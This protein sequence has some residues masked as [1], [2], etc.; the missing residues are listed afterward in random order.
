MFNL[1]R[2]F[3]T[4]SLLLILV[5]AG[6][7]GWLYREL[8][9]RQ[10]GELAESRNLEMA[11]VFDNAL[12]EDIENW[13]S[14]S[15]GR[16]P[17]AMQVAP[18]VIELHQK[19]VALLHGTGVLQVRLCNRLGDTVFST[20]IARIGEKRLQAAGFRSAINGLAYSELLHYRRVEALVGP[21]SDL[22]V[23]VSHIPLRAAD[24]SVIGSLE[25]HQD[26]SP[27]MAQLRRHLWLVMGGVFGVSITLY[28]LQFLVVRRAQHILAEQESRLKAAR[29]TLEIQVDARTDKLRQ[30]N[31]RLE[32]EIGIR[33][34]AEDKLNYLAYHDPLTGLANRQCFIERLEQAMAGTQ[35]SARR[36]AVLLV[37]LDQFK[38]VN[39]SLG[40]AVGD[41]LLVAVAA[42]LTD[43]VR[44]ID[45]L[46]RLGGDEF[47]CL[48]EGVR[49]EADVALLATDIRNAFTECFV[50]G[51]H[52]FFLSASIGIS[53][54]PG[55]GETALEL[56][57]NGDT[58][59]YRAKAMGRGQF[60]FYTPEMTRDARE[61]I[62]LENLL[63][64]ALNNGELSVHFQPQV[65]AG[66]GALIG[67]EALARWDNPRLGSISPLRFIPIAE[68][69]G[70]IIELGNWVLRETCRQVVEWEREGFYLPRVSVNI[71]VRQLERP[72]FVDSL[73]A[74][75]AETG[76][77][78]GRLKLEITESVVMAMGD[79]C[80]LLE[81]LSA[82]GVTLAIDD[83]GTGYSSLSYLKLLPVHQ[84]KIDRSFIVGIGS[85][86]GDE[87]IIETIMA[88]ARSLGF[89]VLAEG[90]ETSGQA[91]FLGGLGCHQFQ[92]YLYGKALS[93]SEF[94]ADWQFRK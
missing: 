37:D 60:H 93:S 4:L 94:A 82:L 42:R 78:P 81:Q 13:V 15:P 21:R 9:L 48:M 75:L 64:G 58:A 84:L 89:E 88:L 17:A 32:S 70:T 29:D 76:M 43:N 1:S 36:L 40:H 39:D 71:S 31:Q 41:E 57:R 87:A 26:V 47:I 66:S 46:A 45:L 85:S 62:R 35:G 83:F 61:R 3:S 34:Q 91:E 65:D 59:M 11:R 20:E 52:E 18:E 79:A 30:A 44:L 38:Q 86:S 54:F 24:Q 33:R 22:D 56:I 7:L 8:S 72:E 53:L 50:I 67:A 25:M 55:D 73:R 23:V 90:V 51:E 49:S 5:A 27:F 74:I 2:F 14:N 12:H 16:E 92:G 28:F 69:S 80:D 68:E 77:A 19:A 63:H 10:M 6:V